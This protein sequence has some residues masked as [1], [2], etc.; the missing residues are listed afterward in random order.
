MSQELKRNVN[1]NP[2]LGT[3]M[4]RNEKEPQ[5]V[6]HLKRMKKCMMN[7][8]LTANEEE[9]HPHQPA[10]GQ[11]THA[12]E[13]MDKSSEKGVH[14]PKSEMEK[15][16]R[17]GGHPKDK[18]KD[19]ISDYTQMGVHRQ[20]N[21]FDTTNPKRGE[22][23]AGVSVRSGNAQGLGSSNAN[24]TRAEHQKVLSELKAMPKP[25]LTRA[26][27]EKDEQLMKPY[28]SNAQRKKFHAMEEK[29]E[30][31]QAKV[32]EWDKTSQG[33][34]L[35][36]HVAKSNMDKA[37][38][39]PPAAPALKVPA[40]PKMQQPK[41]KQPKMPQQKAPS[42]PQAPSLQMMEKNDDMS[43]LAPK[44]HTKD[45]VLNSKI[46]KPQPPKD[47]Y[48]KKVQS[49]MDKVQKHPAISKDPKA[50]I[51]KGELNKDDVKHP[52]GSPEERSHAVA[53]GIVS[54]PQALHDVKGSQAKK[55]FFDHLKSLKDKS[56][57]RSPENVVK[58]EKK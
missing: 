53:E 38:Q 2:P 8:A 45:P 20:A 30:I 54:L 47:G 33:M 39:A 32:K 13:G 27:L 52:A 19:F 21:S 48:N 55:K 34:H 43:H 24:W 12:N 42:K 57:L 18:S 58:K 36:E 5:L 51:F 17:T 11:K 46:A 29:G 4:E 31:S 16:D 26:D 56:Q 37:Q 1:I 15:V 10:Y 28:K 25:K 7:K 14:V 40:M 49:Y 35:P 41:I 9:A 6:H 44:A 50:K 3:N 23:R 22:S